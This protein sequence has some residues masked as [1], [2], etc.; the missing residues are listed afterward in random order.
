VSGDDELERLLREVDATLSGKPAPVAAR[1]GVPARTDE[2][3]T[4]RGGRALRTGL[5][6]GA[7][8]GAGVGTMT[9]LFAWLPFIDNPVSSGMGAFVGAFLT[10]SVLA[11]R[12]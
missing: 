7:V 1:G 8:C 4:G 3:Q 12:R 10:G 5:V 11:F 6:A 2:P 9:F